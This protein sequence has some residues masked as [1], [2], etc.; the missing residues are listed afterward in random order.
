MFSTM[1]LKS[2]M[3][4]GQCAAWIFFAKVRGRERVENPSQELLCP[5]FSEPMCCRLVF[6]DSSLVID[7]ASDPSLVW[8]TISEGFCLFQASLVAQMVKNPSNRHKFDPWV[9]KI[10]RRRTQQLTP[11]FSPGESHGQR[12]LAGYSSWG[13][14]ESDKADATQQAHA[15]LIY[16][17]VLVFAVQQSELVIHI[18]THCQII[19]PYMSLQ[20]TEQSSQCMLCSRFLL[21]IYFVYSSVY[22]SIPIFQFILP[23][24]FPPQ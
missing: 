4:P 22:V 1:K 5:V 3:A 2:L 9:G 21:V 6:R 15:W 18:S 11:V 23:S 19:F 8:V 16:N 13:C 20:S 14:K 12:G 24:P 10:P 7:P 17:I